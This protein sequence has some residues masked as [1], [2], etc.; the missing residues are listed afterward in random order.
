MK[1]TPRTR[2]LA[3]AS[4]AIGTASFVFAADTPPSGDR[5]SASD[6]RSNTT[7]G[8]NAADRNTA[9]RQDRSGDLSGRSSNRDN[10]G[11]N[12]N[13]P[14]SQ[15]LSQLLGKTVD[16]ALNG[17]VR[18]ISQNFYQADQKR[19]DQGNKDQAQQQDKQLQQA[20]ADLKK[21]FQEKY[22]QE[23]SMADASK[24]FGADFLRSANDLGENAR[25]AGARIGGSQS[26][27]GNLNSRSNA[28]TSGN[29]SNTGSSNTSGSSSN[30]GTSSTGNQANSSTPSS[31]RPGATS[32]DRPSATSSDRPSA[33]SSDRS[34]S[35]GAGS[36]ASSSDRSS[37]NSSDRASGVG[38]SAAAGSMTHAQAMTVPASH[39]LPA[40]TLSVVKEGGDW[41][42]N[43]PDS[44]TP[45]RLQQNLARELSRCN[46]MKAQWPQDAN[47]AQKALAHHVLLAIMD[48][49]SSRTGA[50]DRGHDTGAHSGTDLGNGSS[51]D[52]NRPGN[53]STPGND[54]TGNGSTTGAGNTTTPRTT[55]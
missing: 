34:S 48:Q 52:R 15:A 23:L 24:V 40:V 14:D 29:R 13:T 44:L 49:D 47:E 28:D 32:S 55:R 8:T 26:D 12:A 33:T 43:V 31:E 54:A 42:L 41:K 27:T 22:H 45:E 11:N 18:Q 3:V 51:I 19:F 37:A 16:A 50:A 5:P 21:S 35:T 53:S 25:P 39:G 2:F 7:N 38:A 1:S 46:D 30:T 9:D 6:T 10:T 4:L 20:T 36:S 17:D